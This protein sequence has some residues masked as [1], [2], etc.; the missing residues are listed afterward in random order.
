MP[1]ILAA[2]VTYS[3]YIN[4]IFFGIFAAL[5]LALIPMVSWVYKD[6]VEIGINES[7]WVGVV[8]GTGILG[9]V[10]FLVLP[11]FLVSCPI[12]LVLVGAAVGA[13]VFYRN[14]QV[15][16][17]D[18]ILTVSHM[19][20]VLNKEKGSK[21][22]NNLIVFHTCNNNEVPVPQAKTPD[23]YGYKAALD[24]FADAIWR[25]T[26]SIS[27][28]P[29][30]DAY[31]MAY[32]VDGINIKQ[33]DMARD[34]S[35]S[36]IT[37]LKNLADLNLEDK[38]KPQNGKFS[39]EY[40]GKTYAWDVSTA[41]ST[42]GEQVRMRQESQNT[43]L[44]LEDMTLP[45]DILTTL[46]GLRDKKSGVFIVSG[47]PKSGLTT[48]FYTLIRSHDAFLNSISTLEKDPTGDVPNVTQNTYSLSDTGISSYGHKV[49]SLMRMAPDIVG[50]GECED[51]ETAQ[52]IA[53]AA[54]DGML[55]YVVI[56]A[57][58][59]VKALVKWI[60]LTGSKNLAIDTLLGISN[61]RLL[62]RLCETCKQAYTPNKEL[63]RKFNLPAEKAK[64]LYRD[65]KVIYD[66]HGKPLTCEDCQ[67][68]GFKERMGI[69][70]A[71]LVNDAL[72][73]QLKASKN[74]NE[75]SGALRAAKMRNLQEQVLRRI[76]A[77][78]TAINEMVRTFNE[79]KGKKASVTKK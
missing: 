45:K 53:E 43:V 1:E 17:F 6:S 20:S 64:V 19:M 28:I 38:R 79:A 24:L 46:V 11:S 61:Q 56:N 12:Y 55:V 58:S 74:G 26:D 54:K 76:I 27:L 73:N 71:V 33:P 48:T 49:R 70:E 2:T 72:R 3:G 52:V 32:N 37:F 65:G 41:G 14:S 35:E 13:Y 68:V 60:K 78:D 67:G 7:L 16:D 51:A 69:F 5:L 29:G 21:K 18:K 22:K 47:P 15:A 30:S 63:L 9:I 40:Q 23:Y 77:G 42:A 62:R 25:R 44:R 75:I 39:L 57:E 4:P 8:I 34:Q 10:M 36:L 59:S 66:K 31:R 50:V